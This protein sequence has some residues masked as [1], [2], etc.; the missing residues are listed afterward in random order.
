MIVVIS[1]T[2]CLRVRCIGRG[3]GRRRTV[4]HIGALSSYVAP[5]VGSPLPM[6]L[7]IAPQALGTLSVCLTCPRESPALALTRSSGVRGVGRASR[8]SSLAVAFHPKKSLSRRLPFP[9]KSLG[10]AVALS[11]RIRGV[12]SMLDLGSSRSSL[13][14][15]PD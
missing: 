2:H 13:N 15:D 10:I 5:I 1:P 3:W 9:T 7:A 8:R 12:Y 6:A 14:L 11:S 4:R